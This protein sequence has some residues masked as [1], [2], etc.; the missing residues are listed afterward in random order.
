M[1][2][3]RLKIINKLS[4]QLEYYKKS[5]SISVKKQIDASANEIWKIISLEGNLNYI[6][7][8]CK[9]NYSINW[10]GKESKDVLEYLNGLKFIREFKLW[11]PRTGYS[12]LIGTKKGKKSFVE[13]EITSENDKNYLCIT[14][15][16][17]YM[18]QYPKIFSYLPY[19][20]KIKP[21]LTK[22]LESVIGG[23]EYFIK[24]KKK[25]PKNYFGQ[26]EWF[27]KK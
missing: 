3:N 2:E 24:N 1:L 12:L 9:N 13:W 6:H 19:T 25:I 18:R 26:H 14:V 11:K 27:S 23:L 8:F 17:H 10:G 4:V 22:Y 21:H 15:F 7:P 20:F 16:P 5:W